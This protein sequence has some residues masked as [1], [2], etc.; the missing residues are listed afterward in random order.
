MPAR[1]TSITDANTGTAS[2]SCA[3]GDVIVLLLLNSANSSV[4]ATPTGYSNPSTVIAGQDGTNGFAMR[5]VYKVAT[6]TVETIPSVSTCTSIVASVYS[7]VSA[8]TPLSN[9]L[10]QAGT[11]ATI[12]YSGVVSFP[13]PTDWVITVGVS[14][15]ISGNIG[16]HPP[17]STSLVAEYKAGSDDAAIMDSNGPL[18]SYSFNSKTLDASIGW[19][20]K[21]FVLNAGTSSGSTATNLFFF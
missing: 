7:G 13:S 17:N 11:S 21:T 3:V 9:V 5:V 6:S 10:G 20:T 15:S 1:V 8:A 2:V 18:S 4:P 16:L 19:I 12:S 14:G